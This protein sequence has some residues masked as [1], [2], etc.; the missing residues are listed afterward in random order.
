MTEE[1]LCLLMKVTKHTRNREITMR[2]YHDG[3]VSI[4]SIV[5]PKDMC[6]RGEHAVVE[7]AFR[8]HYTGLS[9]LTVG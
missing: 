1:T 8:L 2:W 4:H 6:E 5:S 9:W 7:R 3:V